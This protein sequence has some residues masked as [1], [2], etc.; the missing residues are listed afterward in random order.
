MANPTT[1]N[2]VVG[3]RIVYDEVLYRVTSAI[4]SGEGI[5]PGTNVEATTV[6]DEIKRLQQ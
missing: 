1:Y 5:V 2:H 6:T 3:S 4:A